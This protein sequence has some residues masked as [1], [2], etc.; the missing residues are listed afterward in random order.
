MESCSLAADVVLS[1][2]QCAPLIQEGD[3]YV[4]FYGNG[5]GLSAPQIRFIPGMLSG[6]QS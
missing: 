1:S 4:Y 5:A 2:L 6:S 3:V